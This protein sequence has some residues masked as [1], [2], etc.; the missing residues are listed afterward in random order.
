MAENYPEQELT[1]AQEKAKE[2]Y[3]RY[4]MGEMSEEEFIK[5]RNAILHP[6]EDRGNV[7]QKEGPGKAKKKS[8]AG[9]W[10]IVLA[11]VIVGAGVVFAI[12]STGFRCL[13]LGHSKDPGMLISKEA[14][15]KEEGQISKY[16]DICGKMI[17]TETIP[18]TNDHHYENGVCT[19][20]GEKDPR[21]M[22]VLYKVRTLVE[23]H[24]RSGPGTNYEVLRNLPYLSVVNVYETKQAGGYTWSRINHDEWIANDGSWLERVY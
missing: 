2:L 12:P 1:E 16:C 17:G 15:C 10:I 5:R 23:L 21:S 19:V 13:V 20:C 8:N 24:V 11:I 22:E 9:V 14:T 18:K 6:Q 3:T 7:Q 4:Q